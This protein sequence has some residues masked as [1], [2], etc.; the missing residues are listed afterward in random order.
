MIE[1][2]VS[3]NKKL[4]VAKRKD[5]TYIDGQ[6]FDG[7][8][9]KLG[10]SM[11]KVHSGKQIFLVEVIKQDGKELELKIN[12]KFLQITVTDHID[13]ILDQL[14]MN[15]TASNAVQDV[16]APMPGAIL[17]VV[18][19]EGTEVQKGDQ[20]LILEAMKMENVIKS[21]GDGKVSKVH[22]SEKENVEKNQVLISFE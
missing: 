1:V 19:E 11:F 20:L 17:S 10:T 12:N 15:M 13:K 2:Q 9:H 21:P 4:S 5:G 7:E 22:V 8:I 14:G 3:E 6:L 18:V 16:K